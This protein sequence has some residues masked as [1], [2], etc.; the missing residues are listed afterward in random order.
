[1]RGQASLELLVV[2]A[3]VFAFAAALLP[4]EQEYAGAA[5]TAVITSVQATVLER[6]TQLAREAWLAGPGSVLGV[7]LVL[8]AETHIEYANGTLEMSFNSSNRTIE[9][10]LRAPPIEMKEQ[11]LEKGK[12]WVEAKN[13]GTRVQVEWKKN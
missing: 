9:R 7:E 5:R 10:Q 12:Y 1:M 6:T 2:L 4:A 8:Q 3:A 13:E 11:M